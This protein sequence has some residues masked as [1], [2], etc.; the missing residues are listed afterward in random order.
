[1]TCFLLP[2]C[3]P[4][5]RSS[6]P[7]F[8]GDAWSQGAFTS[9]LFAVGQRWATQTSAPATPVTQL[10]PEKRGGWGLKGGS[11]LSWRH[12][13][14]LLF[15]LGRRNKDTLGFIR[16]LVVRESVEEEIFL[17]LPPQRSFLSLSPPG[18]SLASTASPLRRQDKPLLPPPFSS[19]SAAACTVGKETSISA[20]PPPP[21]RRAA[22]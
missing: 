17:F 19:F 13:H 14:T 4:V 9:G 10:A 22:P 21:S 11:F 8:L 2:V 20:I 5:F 7:P 1:M 16:G 15:F 18:Y 12:F 3:P 6:R